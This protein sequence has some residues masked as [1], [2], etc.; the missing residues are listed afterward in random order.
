MSETKIYKINKTNINEL[1]CYITNRIV[2]RIQI[3]LKESTY[4][5]FRYGNYVKRLDKGNFGIVVSNDYDCVNL[6]MTH[7]KYGNKIKERRNCV[8][9]NKLVLVSP[10]YR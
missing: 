7:D 2:K 6:V 4:H 10:W 3:P 1:Y 5:K 8:S 9:E